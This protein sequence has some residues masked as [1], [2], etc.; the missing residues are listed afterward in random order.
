MFNSLEMIDMFFFNW[1]SIVHILSAYLDIVVHQKY[2]IWLGGGG[3]F[4]SGGGGGGVGGG[5][6]DYIV[7]EDT[8]FIS[9]MNPDTSDND[10]AQL[11]GSI[12]IIKVFNRVQLFKIILF[13]NGTLLDLGS[14]PLYFTNNNAKLWYTGL[15]NTVVIWTDGRI[16]FLFIIFFKY[17]IIF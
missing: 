15:Y 4:G 3:K 8:V 1:C 6:G 2:D 7:Q 14:S 16:H 17:I 9:G 5:G 13:K 12:G 11:F 10:I